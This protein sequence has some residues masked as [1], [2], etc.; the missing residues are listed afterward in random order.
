MEY[1]LLLE[2][3][4]T[5]FAGSQYQPNVRTVQGT[6]E[7]SIIKFASLNKR[8]KFA[9]RTDSGVHAF[10]QVVKIDIN[11][12]VNSFELQSALNHFLDIDISIKSACTV[13]SFF[14]PRSDAISRLYTYSIQHGQARSPQQS[15]FTW[16]MN[17]CLDVQSM[18]KAIETLPYDS[19]DWSPFAGKVP[20]N[21]STIRQ[22]Q[23][24]KMIGNEK[25]IQVFVQASGFLPHQVRRMIGAIKHVGTHKISV[26]EFE[27]LINGPSGSVHFTA[28]A[29]GLNLTKI[30]Y[31]M[32]L[33]Q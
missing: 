13:D 23:S 6:L 2:Y 4:G 25:N 14:N 1:A 15:R 28:P 8:T 17:Y 33:F 27:N 29:K 16:Q 3:D 24:I 7:D 5:N 9:S 26:N 21:Y 20:E 11:K 18:K 12:E 30:Q 19:I 10:G 22:L 32:P 31:D